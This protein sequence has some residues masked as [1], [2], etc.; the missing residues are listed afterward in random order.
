MAF[1]HGWYGSPFG[2]SGKWVH[3]NHWV[4][5]TSTGKIVRYHDPDKFVNGSRRDIGAV[6]YP[7]LGPYDV[8]S[9][10]ALKTHFEWAEEAGI[11]VFIFDWF[12]PPGGYIDKN[13]EIMLEAAVKYNT[14][15]KFAILYDGYEYR[16]APPEEVY[17]ELYYIITKYSN[18]SKFLKIQGYAVIFIYSSK[19]FPYTTWAEIIKR[20]RGKGLKVVFLCDAIDDASNYLKVFDGL[21]TY[22]PA[23]ILNSGGDLLAVYGRIVYEA[24]K[25]NTLFTL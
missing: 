24:K 2:P 9:L 6:D 25:S 1:Y 23:G 11:D 4:M 22:T 13:F 20:L 8:R 17:K 15:L 5:D 14:S 21:F 18:H 19:H 16:N 3:W 12:G 10:D 7:I